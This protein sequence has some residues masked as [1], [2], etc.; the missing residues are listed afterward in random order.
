MELEFES[1]YEINRTAEFIISKSF[2]RIALQVPNLFSS[3]WMKK[4][5]FVS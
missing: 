5:D 4:F 1:K 2:T 3:F